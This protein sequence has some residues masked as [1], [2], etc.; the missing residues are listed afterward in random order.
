MITSLGL[1]ERKKRETRHRLGDVAARLFAEH[2]FDAV[3]VSDVA[4]A[5]DV[6]EQT[7]YNYFPS[8]PDLVLDRDEEIRERVGQVVRARPRETTP[9]DALLVIVQEDIE[10]FVRADATIAKGEFP[11]QCLESPVL[12]RFALESRARQ[13][14]T[15]ASAILE[16][17]PDAH[18]LV[19]RAHA[20]ALVSVVQSITDRIGR[21]ILDD[22]DR[23][24]VAHSLRGDAALALRNLGQHFD[25]TIAAPRGRS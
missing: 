7:V 5:A 23:T 6:S 4:R 10:R 21:A 13:A 19:V 22:S 9:A 11:A 15:I 20:A 25:A 16:T 1:R 8:K 3:S 14:E 12:R 24:G 17:N 2:G 18:D